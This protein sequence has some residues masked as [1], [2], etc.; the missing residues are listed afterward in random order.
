MRQWYLGIIVLISVNGKVFTQYSEQETARHWLDWEWAKLEP[1]LSAYINHTD[2]PP[3]HYATNTYDDRFA[4]N[5][6]LASYRSHRL[7][8]IKYQ[9][10]FVRQNI[11]AKIQAEIALLI[12]KMQMMSQQILELNWANKLI[13]VPKENWSILLTGIKIISATHQQKSFVNHLAWENSMAQIFELVR[14]PLLSPDHATTWASAI[15]EKHLGKA[16]NSSDT[17]QLPALDAIYRQHWMVARGNQFQQQAWALLERTLWQELWEKQ[18]IL[19]DHQW[20]DIFNNYAF[21]LNASDLVQTKAQFFLFLTIYRIWRQD[22]TFDRQQIGQMIYLIPH[23]RRFADERLS[24]LQILKT[25]SFA[26]LILL[27]KTWAQDS[28]NCNSAAVNLIIAGF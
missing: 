6:K 2:Q 10:N 12:F 1:I 18:N 26:E 15:F 28:S 25:N 19:T 11:K 14:T 23:A 27:L 21:F 5:P 20:Q 3:A 16:P 7:S 22:P 13:N 4:L 8:S 17:N 9:Y 24:I